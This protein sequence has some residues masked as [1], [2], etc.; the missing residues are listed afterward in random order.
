MG[1]CVPVTANAMSHGFNLIAF[2]SFSLVASDTQILS[3]PSDSGLLPAQPSS[4]LLPQDQVQSSAVFP[5]SSFENIDESFYY[6]DIDNSNSGITNF[7]ENV[8]RQDLFAGVDGGLVVV[9]FLAAMGSTLLAP[10]LS[11]GVSRILSGLPRLEI[12]LPDEAGEIEVEVNSENVSDEEDEEIEEE[13]EAMEAVTK[14]KRS[15][16]FRKYF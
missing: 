8:E 13:L 11:S 12:T 5:S 7:N 3:K 9:S 2:I 6:D 10:V 1:S 14:V 16:K 4:S 15:P